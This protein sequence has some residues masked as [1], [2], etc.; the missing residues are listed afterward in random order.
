VA[1]LARRTFRR[2]DGQRGTADNAA[3]IT[4]FGWDHL[5]MLVINP[6]STLANRP[7]D[8]LE[9]Q[10]AGFCDAPANNNAI[11]VQQS[12]DVGEHDPDFE[13]DIFQ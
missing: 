7:L 12:G 1:V 11:G 5:E 4:Q 8:W 10:R 13:S 6:G 2:V 9:D 3:I